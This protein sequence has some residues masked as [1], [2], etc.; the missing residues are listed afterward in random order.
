[1]NIRIELA[2]LIREGLDAAGSKS[3]TVFPHGITLDN[4]LSSVVVIRQTSLK[5]TP[6]A[7]RLYQDVTLLVALV[8]PGLDPAKVED[9][10][11]TDLDTLV[12]VL[13]SVP[14]PGLIWTS[15]DRALYDDRFNGYDI[16]VTITTERD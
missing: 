16:A 7:P 12:D 11:D 2:R 15:A 8:E 10:L 5:R 14:M 1:M 4:P 9:A 6:G 3:W 13:E